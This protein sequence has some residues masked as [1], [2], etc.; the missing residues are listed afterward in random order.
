M[1][2]LLTRTSRKPAGPSNL[3]PSGRTPDE[4]IGPVPWRHRAPP[5]A[6]TVEIL[7][8]EADGSIILWQ[9]AQVGFDLCNSMRWRMVELLVVSSAF[10]DGTLG[11]GGGG[12]VP[13]SCN[14]THLPRIVGAVRSGYD[15]TVNDAGLSEQAEPVRVGQRDA[16]ELIAVDPLD[17]IV[18]GQTLIKERVVR[19]QQIG[20]AAI[21]AQ[22][23]FNQKLRLLREGLTQVLVEVRK[24]EGIRQYPVD[25]SQI[26]ILANE[27]RHHG[28]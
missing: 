8:C 1:S 11:G 22:R 9:A 13:R 7:Q 27:V 26:Q 5:L 23:A 19:F 25:V 18:F 6:E 10:N 4:S 28:L 17:P 21:L 15:V 12:G 20:D 2:C 24:V 16:S 3:V 14:S